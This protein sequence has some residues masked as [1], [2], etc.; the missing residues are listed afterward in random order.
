VRKWA[1][2]VA[3]NKKK[4][5]GKPKRV[6]TKMKVVNNNHKYRHQIAK[7]KTKELKVRNSI[8][9]GFLS[10]SRLIIYHQQPER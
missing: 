8:A 10:Y 2:C 3:K 7:K 9:N 1:K 5:A 6:A 4:T